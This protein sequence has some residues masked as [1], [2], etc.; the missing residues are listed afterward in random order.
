MRWEGEIRT[1]G[2]DIRDDIVADVPNAALSRNR[3]IPMIATLRP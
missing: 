3:D 2:E 1:K